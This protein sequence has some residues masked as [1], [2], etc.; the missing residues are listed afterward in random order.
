MSCFFCEKLASF[1]QAHHSQV[2]SVR[3]CCV[4]SGAVARAARLAGAVRAR[5]NSVYYNHDWPVIISGRPDSRPALTQ[6]ACF[7]PKTSRTMAEVDADGADGAD[8]ANDTALALPADQPHVAATSAAVMELFQQHATHLRVARRAL[9]ASLEVGMVVAAPPALGDAAGGP[10]GPSAD[11]PTGPSAGPPN[12]PSA[13]P[14]ADAVAL[15]AVL[16]TDRFEGDASLRTLHQLLSMVDDRGYQRSPQQVRFHDA[17]VRAT[18]RVIYRK[19]WSM[20]RPEIMAHNEWSDCPSQILVS[21]PR[22][23][24]KTFSIAIFVASL[25]LACGLE[26]VVFSPA[27]RASRKLLERIVEFIRLLDCGDRI[28]EFNQEQ[29]RINS[30]QGTKTSLIR[31]FPSKV[32][33][34]LETS[35]PAFSEFQRVRVFGVFDRFRCVSTAL[36]SFAQTLC[37]PHA[38]AQKGLTHTGTHAHI[39]T[40]DP[41]NHLELARSKRGVLGGGALGGRGVCGDGVL[42]GR[43]VLGGGGIGVAGETGTIKLAKPMREAMR[44]VASAD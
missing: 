5:L 28:V 29:C 42:G 36:N 32:Q 25:A 10:A 19:E 20:Q 31:S 34:R 16:E 12:G 41:P 33:T 3:G 39:H 38:H 15:G 11:A 18:S 8:G 9:R 23:F 14:S 13:G 43:G 7:T 37:S 22:R 1:L 40:L 26:V 4:R 35:L 44:L 2:C 17:F 21:T 27:R 6:I 24:G 30:F